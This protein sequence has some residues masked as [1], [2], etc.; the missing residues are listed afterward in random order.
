MFDLFLNPSRLFQRI[1]NRPG[2]MLPFV[3][4]VL[5]TV[6]SLCLLTPISRQV[7]MHTIPPGMDAAKI[8]QLQSSFKLSSYLSL[9]FTPIIVFV[10]IGILTVLFYAVMVLAGIDVSYRRMLSLLTYASVFTALDRLGG[11]VMNYVLGGDSIQ[12]AADVQSTFLSANAFFDASS[13]FVRSL[14]DSVSPLTLWYLALIALGISTIARVPRSRAAIIT[15]VV[16]G[17]QTGF[18]SA[19]SLLLSRAN[20]SAQ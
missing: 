20:A 5:L 13:P 16:W 1:A 9:I 15:V 12:R 4:V 10:R 7:F 2:W 18:I 11:A 19:A 14:F 6:A 8:E 3:A 17:V